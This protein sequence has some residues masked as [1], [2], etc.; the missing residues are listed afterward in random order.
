[1]SFSRDPGG[2]GVRQLSFAKKMAITSRQLSDE[3]RRS[4]AEENRDGFGKNEGNKV[5]AGMKNGK[6]ESRLG[7]KRVS[8]SELDKY[9][10]QCFANDVPLA[11][12]P[13]GLDT[14]GDLADVLD[15]DILDVLDDPLM[16][17]N[18]TADDMPLHRKKSAYSMT[19]EDLQYIIANTESNKKPRRKV[20]VGKDTKDPKDHSLRLRDVNDYDTDAAAAYLSVSKGKSGRQMLRGESFTSMLPPQKKSKKKDDTNSAADIAKYTPKIA[21]AHNYFKFRKGKWVESETNYFELLVDLFSEG[22]LEILYNYPLRMFLAHSMAC[23]PMRISKKFVKDKQIGKQR[24]VPLSYADVDA[25]DKDRLNSIRS[26]FKRVQDDFLALLY[27]DIEAGPIDGSW[28]SK[29]EIAV[30]VLWPSVIQ[31]TTRRRKFLHF[32]QLHVF[33]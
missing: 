11:R 15:E 19:E 7:E 10:E 4:N 18:S 13:S 1:M 2:S 16:D 24:Y 33:V 27:K 28:I 3:I 9:A 12:R 14:I 30:R 25:Y 31:C 26:D 20:L 17:I 23:D 6:F 8:M 32:S 22:L 5:S 21:K 29:D